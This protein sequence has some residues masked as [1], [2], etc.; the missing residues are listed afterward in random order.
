[1]YVHALVGVWASARESV[2]RRPDG[3]AR[4]APQGSLASGVDNAAACN[5]TPRSPRKKAIKLKAAAKNEAC[6]AMV[7]S[8]GGGFC[9]SDSPQE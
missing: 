3:A 4:C 6:M 9:K 2:C 1:M 5:T 8:G 7:R